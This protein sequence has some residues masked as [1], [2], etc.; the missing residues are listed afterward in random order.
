MKSHTWDD[1]P[2]GAADQGQAFPG[3]GRTNAEQAR[4]VPRSC[5]TDSQEVDDAFT[6]VQLLCLIYACRRCECAPGCYCAGNLK[7]AERKLAGLPLPSPARAGEKQ[8]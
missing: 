8:K 2:K 4:N 5:K 3:N 1:Q 6:R 7:W